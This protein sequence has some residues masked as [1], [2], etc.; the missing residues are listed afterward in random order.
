MAFYINFRQIVE[1]ESDVIY[2]TFKTEFDKVAT[3]TLSLPISIP[4]TNYY[5]GLKVY[6]RRTNSIDPVMFFLFSILIYEC[7]I[8]IL[9]TGKEET[10]QNLEAN[11][12]REESFSEKS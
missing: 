11:Y 7:E 8:E 4:G 3:G 2:G 6:N 12:G 1:S 9:F 10:H 5:E